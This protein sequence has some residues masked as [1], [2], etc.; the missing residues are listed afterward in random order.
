MNRNFILASQFY[1]AFVSINK[2]ETRW[3]WCTWHVDKAWKEE[4]NKLVPGLEVQA[5]IYK[6][7]RIVLEQ[8]E[9]TNFDQY[10]AI[11]LERL[12]M[13]KI[14][15]KFALY[16]QKNWVTNINHWG[17]CFRLGDGINTNMFVEAF[18]RVFKYSYLKVNTTKEW[19]YAF[20]V[21]SN[22]IEIKCSNDW[23]N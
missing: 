12:N 23:S 14:T 19:T 8:T 20:L 16:F 13:S 6:M 3:L 1:E 7:L 10:L 22:I 2:Y 4:L 9:R 15:K 17:Y 21:W 18:H 5:D 11:V